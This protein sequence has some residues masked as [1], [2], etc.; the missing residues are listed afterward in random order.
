MTL[1]AVAIGFPFLADFRRR[2]FFLRLKIRIRKIALTDFADKVFALTLRFYA[3][4]QVSLKLQ[5][6]VVINCHFSGTSR[7]FVLR[8]HFDEDEKI[9]T[10]DRG[11]CINFVQQP[12]KN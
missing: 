12:C 9:E 10:D 5:F 3:L 7:P 6:E 1:N 11:F 4:L 2:Q 8:V